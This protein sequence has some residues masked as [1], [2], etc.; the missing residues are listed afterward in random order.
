MGQGTGDQRL[1]SR[2]RVR[3]RVMRNATLAPTRDRERQVGAHHGPVVAE[4]VESGLAVVDTHSAA[5]HPTERSCR[6][7]HLS[8]KVIARH[9]TT[10]GVGN[11]AAEVVVVGPVLKRHERRGPLVDVVDDVRQLR[12]R[13]DDQNRTRTPLRRRSSCPRRRRAQS[14][15]RSCESPGRAAIHPQARPSRP[16]HLWPGHRRSTR[17]PAEVGLV[18][19]EQ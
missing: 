19:D 5:A 3:L 11:E 7:N 2:R 14:L 10:A 4:R 16:S 1:L 13:S 6:W 12:I 15:V 9:T 17:R 18:H 8:P